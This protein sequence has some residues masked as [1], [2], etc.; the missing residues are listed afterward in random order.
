MDTAQ[1][2]IS[3]LNT[4]YLE[5]HKNK[6]DLFW[7]TYMGTSKDMEGFEKA[8]I[9]HKDFIS[10]ETKLKEI[11]S[12]LN[13][14][15][16]SDEEKNVLKGWKKLY[17]CQVI[18]K[19]EAK[20][21][22]QDIIN[23]ENE[24]FSKRKQLKLF[25][26][27]EKGEK[28]EA[29]TLRLATNL[30]TS[31]IES[32]RKS[33]HGELLNLEKWILDNGF[34]EI[35]KK[36]NA[37]ARELGFSNYFECSV[38]QNE[39]MS[40][41]ELFEILDEFEVKTR[42]K[43]FAQFKNLANSR[44]EN[45]LAPHN[46]KYSIAGSAEKEMDPY[47]PFE[48]SVERWVRSFNAMG[49]DY[50]KAELTLDLF[51][52]KGKYENGFM[53]GPVPCFYDENNKWM[54]AKINFTSNANP[55]QVGS[56]YKG[57]NT[58]FHEGGHAA[59]FSN[60]TQ[61][62]PCFSQE[63]PPTSMAYAETQSM[64]CDSLLSDADWLKLYATSLDG[65]NISDE[66]IKNYISI[67]QPFFGYYERS[68]LVVPYFE[69]I[70][71]EADEEQLTPE[72]LLKT[73]RECEMKIL[74]LKTSPRP[75]L[76]I[77]HL[78][79]LESA[80]CYHGYLLANMA[81]YQTRAHFFET[82]GYIVNNPNIGPAITKAYWNPGNSQS[83]A[84]TLKNLTGKGFSPDYLANHCNMSADELWAFQ[85]ELI[86]KAKPVHKSYEDIDLN[87]SIAIVHGSEKISD[88][89]QGYE[90]L[91]KDFEDWVQRNYR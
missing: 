18:R 20:Q 82:E 35:V 33:S 46:L 2:F 3:R 25:F 44:G 61:K 9:E 10:D 74:G 89:S 84:Q 8:E 43:S 28:V 86:K 29:S 45:A 34:I 5:V 81:V 77:P 38:Q 64:F 60:I 12:Y 59:H 16:T 27:D 23:L 39:K 71:Y 31:D 70:V 51:D 90:K 4:S 37:F 24:L 50:K 42:S 78:L 62:A 57:L 63:F 19:S 40:T 54:P 76:T 41:E 72:F 53:H 85:E 56:G 21:L 79:S 13:N 7:T 49:I 48:K 32:V 36:R 15:D 65:E 1:S 88:N 66:I 22:Q 52:R 17:D 75:I 14:P 58:L 83:H 11:E 91:F 55:D 30:S 47:M 68:I 73:A 80:C 67:Q 26:V 6:E 69:R 87:A